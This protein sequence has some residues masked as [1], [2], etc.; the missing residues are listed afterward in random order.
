MEEIMTSSSTYNLGIE[1]Y[2][3]LHINKLPEFFKY[4][5]GENN[6]TEDPFLETINLAKQ[7]FMNDCSLEQQTLNKL[8]SVQYPDK[9][10]KDVKERCTT[11]INNCSELDQKY[12]GINPFLIMYVVHEIFGFFNFEK[13]SFEL[14]KKYFDFMKKSGLIETHAT[15]VNDLSYNPG[16][17]IKKLLNNNPNYTAII[18]GCGD[19]TK[20][21]L[22]SCFW[23]LEHENAFTVDIAPTENPDVVSDMHDSKL[24]EG[25][26]DSRLESIR[27]HTHG[28]FLF[29]DERY[30]STLKNIY[31]CLKPNG[32]FEF[33]FDLSDNQKK[34]LEE[35]GFTKFDKKKAYK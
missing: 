35:A 21:Y 31:R 24:W 23:D 14:R 7:G 28:Y 5:D 29:N 18:L 20:T 3:S 4:I 25:I 33:T 22:G 8:E 26:Y 6:S 11:I 34:K 13:S 27:D 16:Q 12:Q 9:H 19:I 17:I 32:Y 15:N 30:F 10:V 1:G 2:Y